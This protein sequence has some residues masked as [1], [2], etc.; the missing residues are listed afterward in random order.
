MFD[1]ALLEVTGSVPRTYTRNGTS[2]PTSLSGI[3]GE[4]SQLS[5]RLVKLSTNGA[6]EEATS[7]TTITAC[8]PRTIV[9]VEC[10]PNAAYGV[11]WENLGQAETAAR[12]TQMS[13]TQAR[14]CPSTGC[15]TGDEGITTAPDYGDGTT[16]VVRHLYVSLL[17]LQFAERKF[18]TGHTVRALSL[19]YL[20]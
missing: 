10:Q 13:I 17:T 19:G 9:K 8:V 20:D 7:N 5:T 14:F 16:F 6:V 3:S 2:Y 18:D 15:P 11:S 1:A 12:N 4:I